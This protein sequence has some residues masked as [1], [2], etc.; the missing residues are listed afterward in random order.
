MSSN[1]VSLVPM[2]PTEDDQ[3]S[4]L[5][6]KSK[7]SP[8]VPIGIAGF[9]SV[10]AYGLYKLKTRGNRKMSVHLIHMRVAAQGCVVGAMTI[11][12]LWSMYKE[13]VVKPREQKI[14]LL[15]K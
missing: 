15:Q 11:G 1:N 8:F 9:A 12:V 4:K 6:R 10:V 14:A 3:T 5:I 2:L 7:E 13:Y